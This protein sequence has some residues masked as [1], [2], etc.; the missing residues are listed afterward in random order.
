MRLAIG[1]A[2]VKLPS[3]SVFVSLK[4]LSLESVVMTKG[5]SHLLARLLSTVCCPC[6]Q[7]LRLRDVSLHLGGLED[8]LLLLEAAALLELS[9]LGRPL[10]GLHPAP[11]TAPRRLQLQLHKYC[12]VKKS[13]VE[14]VQ[15][16]EPTLLL[17]LKTPNLQVL[18]MNACVMEKLMI[19]DQSWRSSPWMIAKLI[20]IFTLMKDPCILARC[21][22]NL[23]LF[24]QVFIFCLLAI[25]HPT[26]TVMVRCSISS[27]FTGLAGTDCELSFMQVMLRSTTQLRKATISFDPEYMMKSTRDAIELIPAPDGGNWEVDSLLRH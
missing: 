8:Q 2:V 27:L 17:E 21:L 22:Q 26:S 3:T 23:S 11:A 7:N 9:P 13:E 12:G 6:L 14:P 20:I 10:V 4:S 15:P 19:S 16:N 24:E 1:R 18:S 25:M 5:T